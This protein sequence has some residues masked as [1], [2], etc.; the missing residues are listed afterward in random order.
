MAD[1]ETRVRTGPKHRPRS[2][3][4]PDNAK[5]LPMGTHRCPPPGKTQRGAFESSMKSPK[6][7][8]GCWVSSRL[9][10]RL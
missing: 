1:L 6:G 7:D 8:N 10:N 3:L 2:S 9:R 4:T 5:P